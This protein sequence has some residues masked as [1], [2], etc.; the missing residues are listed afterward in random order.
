MKEHLVLERTDQLELPDDCRAVFEQEGVASL[1]RD[2]LESLLRWLDRGRDGEEV[3]IVSPV[4]PDYSVERADDRQHRYTFDRLNGGIGPMAARLYGSLSALHTLFSDRLRVPHFKHC[5]CVCD[6]DG[7]YENNLLRLSVTE[8]Q[9]RDKVLGSCKSLGAEAPREVI[10][11][12]LSDH[13]GGKAGWLTELAATRRQLAQIEGASEWERATIRA[14]AQERLALYQRWLG[15]D[16]AGLLVEV[17]VTAQGIEYAT[18]GRI[19]A[20][21]FP[22][23]LVLTAG[24]PR[25]ERFFRAFAALPV[26]CV[27]DP[28][29]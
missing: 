10:A 1:A 19:I 7:F 16:K 8:G 27:S 6:F 21:G 9:F 2:N 4:C 25:W 26:L 17:L 29:L 15:E 12:L 11:S 23:P 3:T 20:R 22:N 18:A 5:F 14:I 24:N 13:C 28:E